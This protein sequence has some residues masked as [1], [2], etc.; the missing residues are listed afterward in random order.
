MGGDYIPIILLQRDLNYQH[1]T[2]NNNSKSRSHPD[3]TDS[4]SS[5]SEGQI[6]A[7]SRSAESGLRDSS[8]QGAA[9]ESSDLASLHAGVGELGQYSV[10][11]ISVSIQTSRNTDRVQPFLQSSSAYQP[12]VSLCPLETGYS[13]DT[14]IIRCPKKNS[15]RHTGFSRGARL[16]REA[17]SD[18][19]DSDVSHNPLSENVKVS[20]L[21]SAGI[22]TASPAEFSP[23]STIPAESPGIDSDSDHLD[24]TEGD[25]PSH[26]K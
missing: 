10:S 24:L 20:E 9:Q 18:A 6:K 15:A 12:T 1:D 11:D 2:I 7:R 4:G 26:H 16:S 25:P 23:S 13:S 17:P 14:G 22:P 21:S 3:R 19:P 8:K 5:T